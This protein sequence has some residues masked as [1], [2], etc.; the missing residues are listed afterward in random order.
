MGVK[1]IVSKKVSFSRVGGGESVKKSLVLVRRAMKFLVFVSFFGAAACSTLDVLKM[2][3]E[4]QQGLSLF[5][6]LDSDASGGINK[7]ELA[8]FV[9]EIGRDNPH[10]DDASEVNMA[11]AASFGALDVN[12]DDIIDAA[13]FALYM[14]M[15]VQVLSVE[16]TCAWMEYAMQLPADVVAKFRE[17]GITGEDFK[18]L[19]AN[20]GELLEVLIHLFLG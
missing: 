3:Q 9:Q 6:T 15:M 5:N 14:K 8:G 20:D 4:G 1:K 16:E 19:I 11:V 2:S 12:G 17:M 18:D 7:Q 10:L 13:E